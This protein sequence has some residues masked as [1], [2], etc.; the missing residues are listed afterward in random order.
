MPL[1]IHISQEYELELED[2]RTKVLNMGGLV[3]QHLTKALEALGEGKVDL[4]EEISSSDYK[5]NSLELTIDE[6]CT[7]ILARR[8]PAASDLRLVL[9]VIKTIR[10]LERIGDETAKIS[11]VTLRLLESESLKSYS[12]NVLAMGGHV[13][14]MLHEALDAFARMDASAAIH[15]AR[16]DYS[17]DRENDAILRQLITYMM[18]DPRSIT[19]VLDVAWMVRAL[20]RIGDHV[21]NICESIIYLVKGKD[22]RHTPIDALAKEFLD[23]AETTTGAA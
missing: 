16:E 8:Q 11:R 3:E 15:I 7:Q 2:I 10:D 22:V 14:Q 6:D 17:V 18:E 19:A 13:R 1:P 23:E 5:V 4:A 20:E 12:I 21:Y 9:T